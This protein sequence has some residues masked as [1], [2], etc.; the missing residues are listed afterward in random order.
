MSLPKLMVAPNG[1]TKTKSDHPRLPITLDE[2][3][4][5]AR[6]CFAAGA[7]GLHLH[8]R[9]AQGRHLLDA[10]AYAEAL[11][12]LRAAVPGMVLQ[13]TTEAA[14]IYEPPHQRRVAL[15]S[16][17]A[18]VS[19]ALRE[20][21]RDD[22]T[23]TR[24]FY[25]DCAAKGIAVQH[26]LY[27]RADA[28]SLARVLPTSMLRDPT[29]QLLFVLGRYTEGQSSDPSMLDPF[30]GW[31]ETAGIEPD[32]M[33]CA[34]GPGESDALLAAHAIGGKMRVGFENSLWHADG[35]IARDNAEQVARLIA[36]LAGQE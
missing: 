34:F 10:G 11:T 33:V 30:T 20:M 1:A 9:D 27:D 35:S 7:D 19:I 15:D 23:V 4:E 25:E 31:L 32:W 36:R 6:A 13:I 22:A 29:L 3:T 21:L 2:I 8:L 28:E 14:G 12:H 26:I 18:L 24:R 17:A 16:G 5:T